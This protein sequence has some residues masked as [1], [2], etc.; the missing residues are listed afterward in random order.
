MELANAA[1]G[2][3]ETLVTPL[4]MALV[5]A[6]I[7]NGGTLMAP[8]LVAEL[9][10]ADGSVEQRPPT[11]WRAVL[12][13]AVAAE[14]RD[15]MVAAVESPLGQPFA[16]AAAVPG[17]V[18]AGKSGTA[19]LGSDAPYSWFIGFAPA[20][21]PR[22][23]VAVLVEHGGAAAQEAVPMAGEFLTYALSLHP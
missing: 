1:Y 4:Q 6:T 19:Q 7:A 16:G 10:R 12:D 23:A 13:A 11:V 18:T 8:E 21:S 14:I 15:A 20:A 2:Q 17:V 5:A 3:A 9:R 22:I